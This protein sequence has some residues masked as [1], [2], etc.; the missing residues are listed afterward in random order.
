MKLAQQA[1][2]IANVIEIQN[3]NYE[4]YENQN[5]MMIWVLAALL[6]FLKMNPNLTIQR[7]KTL[8][9]CHLRWDNPPPSQ[10]WIMKHL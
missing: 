6:Q 4:N 2:M 9:L 5:L 8:R 7:Q 3:E 10:H 1:M